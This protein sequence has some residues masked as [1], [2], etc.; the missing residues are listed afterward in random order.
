MNYNCFY[1]VLGKT[2]WVLY[3]SNSAQTNLSKMQKKKREL[4]QSINLLGSGSGTG[5]AVS[6]S[7]LPNGTFC[8]NRTVLYLCST[9][10]EPLA[11]CE[12]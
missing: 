5:T 7:V 11:T 4:N 12:C 10:Q 3:D 1:A 8:D 6:Q 2:V 9:E